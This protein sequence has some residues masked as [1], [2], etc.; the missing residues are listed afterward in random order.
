MS[1]EGKEMVHRTT[2]SACLA[3]RMLLA[4]GFDLRFEQWE[5]PSESHLPSPPQLLLELFWCPQ[6]LITIL[7]LLFKQVLKD[8]ENSL[9]FL[10][11]FTVW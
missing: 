6:K 7:D 8:S 9:P 11:L 2:F 4:S 10:S 3:P 5:A 1:F